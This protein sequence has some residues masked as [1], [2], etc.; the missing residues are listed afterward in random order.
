[1][2]T[3]SI[4]TAGDPVLRR[5]A[6]AVSPEAIGSRELDDLVR[7]MTLVMRAAPGVGL[8][9]PQ[10]GVPLRV[11]VLEDTEQLMGRLSPR[12]RAARERTP[13]PFAAI[14]NPEIERRGE[15]TPSSATFFEGCLSVP[16]YM[17]LVER[18]LE[19]NLTGLTLSGD[20]MRLALRGWPA[21]IAQHEIDHLDGTLYVDRMIARTLC[22]NEEVSRRWIA[23]DVTK[24]R[25]ALGAL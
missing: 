11:I 4:V 21:R 12:E 6:S 23:E 3:R 8:A 16:G 1:M 19:V 2:K 25:A 15:S 10:I 22:T 5:A 20:T 9:A 24:I 7:E 17:A 18:E 14:V 13:L